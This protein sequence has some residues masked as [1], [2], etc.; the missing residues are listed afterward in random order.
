MKARDLAIIMTFLAMIGG[1]VFYNQV[2]A[3]FAEM[4]PLEA[5]NTI[6]TFVLHVA[7]VTIAV[8]AVTTL[9]D[10]VKPWMRALKWKRKQAKRGG[11]STILRQRSG[12]ALRTRTPRLTSDQ[13]MKLYMM[14]FLSQE[15]KRKDWRR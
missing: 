11:P 13:M 2:V 10:L 14:Q 7:V 1:L 9:P 8:W 6:I 5:L 4:T 12:Q 15:R 3:I